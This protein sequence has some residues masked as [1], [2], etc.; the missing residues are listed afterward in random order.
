MSATWYDTVLYSMVLSWIIVAEAVHLNVIISVGVRFCLEFAW[1]CVLDLEK[2]AIQAL[3]ATQELLNDGLGFTPFV[4]LIQLISC[5]QIIVC[6]V[7]ARLVPGFAV[8]ATMIN[9]GKGKPS[10]S[11]GGSVAS[12]MVR[13]LCCA[14]RSTLSSQDC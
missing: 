1:V 9:E 12:V 10:N 7:F 6:L 11:V 13:V 14:A 5:F 4:H 2:T 3:Q 8:S